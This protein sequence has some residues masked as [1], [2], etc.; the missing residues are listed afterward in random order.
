MVSR[1][2]L[3]LLSI[4]GLVV[5]A[6]QLTKN[7]VV[8]RFKLGGTRALVEGY[9]SLTRVHNPGAA[10]GLLASLAPEIR[11][12][13][14][15][16]LPGITLAIIF[17]FFYRIRENQYL[18]IYALS[19]IVGGAFGNLVDRARI[20]FVIDFIDFHLPNGWHFP[21]FNVADTA[22]TVGVGLLLLGML[23]E[24]EAD[25]SPSV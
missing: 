15:F 20:G 4:N 7:A 19:L 16:L 18:S 6:D 24:K 9:V 5:A 12:P 2:Y 13:F 23:Q 22:I 10:F 11:E 17:L 21:A 1:K 3:I 25:A 14:F 8:G